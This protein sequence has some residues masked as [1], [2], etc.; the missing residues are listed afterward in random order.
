MCRLYSAIPR[1]LAVA[2]VLM[3]FFD[4]ADAGHLNLHHY[5]IRDG[6]PQVQVT[7]V[8]QDDQGYL[9]VGTFGG[10]A[11]YNGY[12]FRTFQPEDGLIS[13]YVNTL[14]LD[15]Q[16][17]IWV[18]TARGVCY[19]HT[20]RFE[21]P[22][23]PGFDGIMVN[24]MA[25]HRGDMWLAAEEGL[26]RYSEG[27]F[28][29]FPLPDGSESV[30]VLSLATDGEG[31]LWAGT[32]AGLFVE[33]DGALQPVAL[34]RESV[35]ALTVEAG[36]LWI[37]AGRGLFTL[38]MAD[39]QVQEIALPGVD[40]VQI[41]NIHVAPD[42][43]LWVA[44]VNGLF[45]RSHD[46]FERFTTAQGLKNNITH[47]ITTDGEGLTWVGT[48]QGLIKILPGPFS[49]FNVDSG[50][51]A[52]F[53]RTI[54]EDEQQRL[55]LGTREGVQVVPY[56]EGEWRFDRSQIIRAAQGLPDNRV[57][58]IVFPEAGA[59]LI[60]TAQGVAHWRDE[61]GVTATI[62][63]ADGLAGNDTQALLI[64]RRDRLWISTTRGTSVME[65]GRLEPAPD[66][67]LAGAH[68]LRI[69]E[70]DQGWLW[71]TTLRSGLLILHPDGR[72]DQYRAE[73]G[74]TDEML[75]DGAPSHDGSMW[76]GSNG[77][78][79]F[80]VWPGGQI[81]QYT[82]ADG[83][84]DNAVWNVIEDDQQRV[85]AYTNQG[86]S[87]LQDDRFTNYGERD[88]LLHLEGGATGALQTHDGL[89]WFASA[90]GLMRY[91]A[92]QE[93]VNLVPPPVL[94]ESV[95]MSRDDIASGA[96]LPY[97]GGSLEFGYT[98]LSFQDEA[99]VSFRYRLIGADDAWS[100]PIPMRNV[101][102]A[103]LGHGEYAFEV[104]AINPHGVPSREPARFEFS[105]LP[106]FWM[107]WWFIAIAA[108]TLLGLTWLFISLRLRQARVVQEHLRETVRQR[109]AELRQLNRKL[110]EA[111][112]TDQLT[113]LRN[114]RYLFDRIADDVA[115]VQRAHF[116]PKK[117]INRDLVFLMVDLDN[118]KQINDEYGHDA[119]DRA[120]KAFSKL[121]LGQM[122][123]SDYTIRW[124]G[125]E[126]LIVACEAEAS[127]AS[128]IAQRLMERVRH[129][130]FEIDDLGTEISITC[131][132]GISYYPFNEAT[133]DTLDWEQVV[134]I[135]DIAVYQ[136]KQ[137][138]RDCW[139]QLSVSED[140]L[141]DDGAEFVEWVR[142]DL[143]GMIS[144]GEMWRTTSQG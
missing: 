117:T 26:F 86:L 1:R 52:S 12:N 13:T 69:R 31:R 120:L 6:L 38:D 77:S 92:E 30:V 94:I 18:G 53:V 67:R 62:T 127:H 131:S 97:R 32:S 64:D 19:Y 80:R 91:E 8:L 141:I 115:R 42:G 114:R 124:G 139:V 51:L 57:N 108:L 95:R 41:N 3:L 107:T 96:E 54:N 121:L 46:W 104:I 110:E 22:E 93:Y 118:F 60:A 85:W 81:R 34:S 9:W 68:A 125:E 29:R 105:V 10:V 35:K 17:R 4:S 79:L 2:A 122:R 39:Q 142:S 111:S 106:P 116:D 99:A 102:Y 133:A 47:H 20:E 58:S 98:G 61:E 90:D 5:D 37:G 113:G 44:S 83:L 45:R 76:I 123:E 40:S 48:D 73:Q 36:L 87:M 138:G 129:E 25:Q 21:C 135:A 24:D 72:L 82:T 74:L 59:A 84:A 126:F 143:E 78:G 14:K 88:G 132:V 27:E 55:W 65:D 144:R 49:G 134:Q 103:N 101:T 140:A 43:V 16:G 71:F 15:G 130:R 109:T 136:A 66:R 112:R 56:V 128:T 100:D 7:S 50:L 70:D 137:M 11:R 89:L 33:S 23:I 28:Q 63:L 119:G 75:W